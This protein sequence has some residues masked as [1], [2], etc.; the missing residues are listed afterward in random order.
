VFVVRLESLLDFVGAV[1]EV[2]H[3]GIDFTRI[4][5]VEP[6]ESLHGL[7]VGEALVYVHRVEQGLVKSRLVFVGGDEDLVIGFG[8]LFGELLFGDLAAVHTDF[9]ELA[10]G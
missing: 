2:E 7:H 10:S 9:G 3:E 8:E 4:D 5:A 6:R 1:D